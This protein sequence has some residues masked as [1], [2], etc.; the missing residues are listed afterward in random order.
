MA[1]LEQSFELRPIGYVRSS[2][3]SREAAPK[4]GSEGA[5]EAWLE[6]EEAFFEAIEG[7]K[8]EDELLVLTWFHRADRTCLK[9]HPRDD[10]TRKPLG[11]F[12]TRSPDRPNPI[13]IH[14]VRV[15][16]IVGRSMKVVPLEAI[17]GTP[18]IDLKP[19][20]RDDY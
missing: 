12:A 14:P 1:H 7:L 13:G 20:L 16:E 19:R 5:P 4:Q 3:K 6:I 8:V 10:R 2:L 9:T 11:V 15:L 17:H 18:I